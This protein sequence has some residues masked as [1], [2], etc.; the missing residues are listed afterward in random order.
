[1]KVIPFLILLIFGLNSDFEKSFENSSDKNSLNFECVEFFNDS[2][3]KVFQGKTQVKS[4][5]RILSCDY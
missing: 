1:M 4:E 5:Q 2:E 3:E